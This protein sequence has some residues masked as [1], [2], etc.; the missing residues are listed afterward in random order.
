MDV[1]RIALPEW[2]VIAESNA[3][4]PGRFKVVV[5]PDL[6][7]PAFMAELWPGMEPDDLDQYRLEVMYQCMKMDLQMAVRS[8]AFDIKVRGDEGRKDRWGLKNHPP[9]LGVEAA[10]K[11]LGAREHYRRIR[12]FVPG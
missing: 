3:A 7:Y 12:G 4:R 6:C 9:G 2:A 5:D 8:F 1:K 10:S 11:G